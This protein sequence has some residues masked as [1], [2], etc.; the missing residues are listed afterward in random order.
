MPD[1]AQAV[2]ERM[3]SD[4]VASERQLRQ[5][6]EKVLAEFRELLYYLA[7]QLAGEQVQEIKRR[8]PATFQSWTSA[9]WRAFFDEVTQRPQPLVA[10]CSGTHPGAG[11][12]PGSGERAPAPVDQRLAGA[13]ATRSKANCRPPSSGLRPWKPSLPRR[14]VPRWDF[15][16]QSGAISDA[17]R[18]TR[19]ELHRPASTL[20]S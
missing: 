10:G 2:R 20:R 3:I 11:G 15:P 13:E 9:Q 14:N 17:P 5:A 1:N 8:D 4:L 19:I 16:R 12:A 18:F 6:A 7:G